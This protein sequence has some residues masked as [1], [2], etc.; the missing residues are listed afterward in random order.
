MVGDLEVAEGSKVPVAA[1]GDSG[2]E[3]NG[4]G[5]NGGD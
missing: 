4:S 5:D 2:D 3:T 1:R